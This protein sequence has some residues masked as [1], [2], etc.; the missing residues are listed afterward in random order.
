M[1][2]IRTDECAFKTAQN[3]VGGS[4]TTAEKMMERINHHRGPVE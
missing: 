4:D 1:V 3:G 2:E